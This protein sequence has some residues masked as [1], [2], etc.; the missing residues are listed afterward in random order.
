MQLGV[1]MTHWSLE[2]ARVPRIF[3]VP[4]A[5]CF[6]RQTKSRSNREWGPLV[7]QQT[8]NYAWDRFLGAVDNWVSL[9]HYEGADSMRHAYLE[10]LNGASPD[11]GVVV[12]V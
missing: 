1:G 6:S 7:Y 10:V 4:S 5:R 11:K 9:E 3:Q 2:M 12:V 8:M